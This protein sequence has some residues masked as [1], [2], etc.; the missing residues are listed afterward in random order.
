MVYFAKKTNAQRGSHQDAF[1]A[2]GDI[3]HFRH[4][5]VRWEGLIVITKRTMTVFWYILIIFTVYI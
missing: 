3:T 2:R 5:Q 1:A 4:R